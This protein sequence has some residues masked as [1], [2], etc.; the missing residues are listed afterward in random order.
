VQLTTAQRFG[1]G[2]PIP[3]VADTLSKNFETFVAL[4][5]NFDAI[6]SR[7]LIL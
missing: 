2:R 6:S 3:N 1:H 7:F 4:A 5:S